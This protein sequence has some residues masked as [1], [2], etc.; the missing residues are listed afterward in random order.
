M[1]CCYLCSSRA[2][3][4]KGTWV[5]FYRATQRY[6]FRVLGNPTSALPR[7]WLDHLSYVDLRISSAS[8]RESSAS[9]LP[10]SV[11]Q[12]QGPRSAYLP[13]AHQGLIPRA[14]TFPGI[15]SNVRYH[16]AYR[17]LPPCLRR[18]TSGCASR[19]RN[20]GRSSAWP[21]SATPT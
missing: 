7:F 4:R 9:V 16:E 14:R 5:P 19:R 8:F 1:F 15:G 6:A 21:K 13:D 12:P 17:V 3:Y 20:G 10:P 2:S 11:V 18:R